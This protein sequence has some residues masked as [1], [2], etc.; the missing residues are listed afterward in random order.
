MKTKF[1]DGIFK[2]DHSSLPKLWKPFF[3]NKDKKIYRQIDKL[4]SNVNFTLKRNKKKDIEDALDYL[5][6]LSIQKRVN[7]SEE[8][9]LVLEAYL[10]VRK[11]IDRVYEDNP[12]DEE[13]L[14]KL[15]KEEK[16]ITERR[17]K[18]IERIK[19][20]DYGC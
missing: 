17:D 20:K 12:N 6:K 2:T 5:W 14:Q 19:N 10:L 16:E 18:L 8:L 3:E 4:Y 1:E 9:F 15:Y 7:L 13:L 11:M